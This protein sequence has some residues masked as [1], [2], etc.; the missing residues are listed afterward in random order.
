MSDLSDDAPD[1]LPEM[2]LGD[3]YLL[4]DADSRRT[5]EA[6]MAEHETWLDSSDQEILR[7]VRTGGH[8]VQ[9]AE[10]GGRPEVQISIYRTGPAYGL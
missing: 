5:I 2:T 4:G 6:L 9:V 1:D 3:A 7:M 8:S 10:I